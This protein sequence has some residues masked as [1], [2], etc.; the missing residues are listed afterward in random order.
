MERLLDK[1]AFD[2]RAGDH[3]I[4][5]GDL[6]TKGPDNVGVVQLAREYGAS[7]VRGNNEDRI[8][9]Y[10]R[11]LLAAG[12]LSGSNVDAKLTTGNNAFSVSRSG[13]VDQ[14]TD[15][16]FPYGDSKDHILARDLNDEDAEWLHNCPVILKLGRIAGMG[17]TVVV[18]AGLLPGVELERQDPF[19][20]MTMRTMDLDTHV[21]SSKR[22]GMSW[23]KVISLKPFLCFSSERSPKKSQKSVTNVYIIYS[24]LQQAPVPSCIPSPSESLA[25]AVWYR[26][27]CTPAN[28]RNIRTHA[29]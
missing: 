14:E 10:R 6:I 7:C 4:F 11:E 16:I 19:A 12:I 20:V 18:H 23:T 5:T 25:R 21:P 2:R 15:R 28:N 8:L 29:S 24:G 27:L 13:F 26:G 1:V 3:L 17:E 22:A 9:L